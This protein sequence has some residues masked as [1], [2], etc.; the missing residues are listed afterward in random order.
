MTEGVSMGRPPPELSLRVPRGAGAEFRSGDRKR[1]GGTTAARVKSTGAPLGK[2]WR[3]SVDQP[4]AGQ[5]IPKGTRPKVGQPSVGCR[6]PGGTYR[7]R[8][9]R[10]G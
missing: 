5:G 9:P 1:V 8:I 4:P 7:K 2:V 10:A 6:Y 3:S